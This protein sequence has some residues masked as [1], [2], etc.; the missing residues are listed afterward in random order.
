MQQM[1]RGDAFARTAQA[2][3][4]GYLYSFNIADLKRRNSHLGPLV[5]DEDIRELEGTLHALTTPTAFS[6]RV[7]SGRWLLFSQTDVLD[8]VL[9]VI[10]G[11]ARNENT[12]AG[13][14]IQA[15]RDGVKKSDSLGVATTISRA[16][17]CIA[18]EVHSPADLAHAMTV[19]AANDHSLPVNRPVGLAEIPTLNRERW[20][21][22]GEYPDEG[23]ACPFCSGRDFAWEHSDGH[24]YSGDGSCA[25]CGARVS[26]T[27]LD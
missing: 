11:F 5:G 7:S 15:E 1:K 26:I 21:C 6:D 27:M 19:I 20:C 16:L 18:A 3:L 23:P 2:H 22:V 12:T 25:S 17:R 10:D 9:A 14:L 13:W 8:R 4:P 24:A